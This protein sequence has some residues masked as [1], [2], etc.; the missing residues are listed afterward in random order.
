MNP[1]HC[2]PALKLLKK[3]SDRLRVPLKAPAEEIRPG[4]NGVWIG[5]KYVL[6]ALQFCRR[7]DTRWI[8]QVGFGVNSILRSIEDRV[9]GEVNEA[10]AA[11][12]AASSQFTRQRSV[13][14][15]RQA[16]VGL[17]GFQVRQRGAVDQPIRPRRVE[18]RVYCSGVE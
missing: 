16:R 10:D 1:L 3:N 9:G 6:F 13:Q 11:F 18:D 2:L 5:R 17:A 8:G 12:Q 15:A 7:I 14:A 4:N